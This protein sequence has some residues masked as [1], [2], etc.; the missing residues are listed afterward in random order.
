LVKGG[1]GGRNPLENV[2]GDGQ[3]EENDRI[4]LRRP[5][6]IVRRRKKEHDPS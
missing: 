2:N 1:V 5:K 3:E 6:G 4:L